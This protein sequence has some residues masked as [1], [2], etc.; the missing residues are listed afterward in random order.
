MALAHTDRTEEHDIG[1]LLEELQSEEVLHL[2]PINLFW[3]VPAELFEGLDDGKGGALDA[4]LNAPVTL[5]VVFSFDEAP[6]ILQMIPLLSGGL[7]GQIA[8]LAVN[9]LEFEVLQ[10]LLEQVGF[11]FHERCAGVRMRSNPVRGSPGPAGP[12]GE[13]GGG[14]P[15]GRPEDFAVGECWRCI[16]SRWRRRPERRRWRVRPFRDRRF[17]SVQ[18]S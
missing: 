14:L 3:P 16:R 10:M 8:M 17:R 1:F 11:V 4:P 18:P 7:G 2:Q 15:A 9:E 13:L 6:E 5:V 12:D